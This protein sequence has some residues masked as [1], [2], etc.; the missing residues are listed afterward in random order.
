MPGE[1]DL[2]QPT[3]P[4]TASPYFLGSQ[5]NPGNLITTVQLRGENYDQ[6]AQAIRLSLRARRKY[7]FVNGTVPKPTTKEA[8]MVE[9]WQTVHSMIVSWLM[10][11]I[12]PT[13]RSTI[14]YYEDAHLLWKDLRERFCV[15]NG[16]RIQQLKSALS[17]CKQSKTEAIV[18]YYG[19][20]KQVWDELANYEYFRVVNVAPVPAT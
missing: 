16:P 3:P 20:L 19:R 14:S 4:H 18:V 10:N 7:G 5:D 15:V 13:L 1:E 2:K 9:D 6:W 12:E 17:E 8:A 11:T